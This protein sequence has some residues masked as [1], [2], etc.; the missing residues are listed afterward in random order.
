MHSVPASCPCGQVALE[1]AGAP[2]LSATC[3]CES[4]RK[5][6]RQFEQ[7]PD[8]PTVLNAE[9][10]VD[11][12]LFR[13][14]RVRI[15]RGAEHLREHRLTAASPTRR[16]VTTCCNAPMFLDFTKGHWL[17]L[18]RDRLGAGAP[19]LE[20]GVMAKERPPGVPRPGGLPAY[21]TYP[22]KFMI[23]LLTTWAAMG[24]RRPRI[25]W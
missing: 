20:M 24:F 8:A 7:A 21:P 19:P 25:V 2:I 17:N 18:Y 23:K 12:C 9:G 11:Y 16:V 5:A 10:G 3:Y 4:C 1:A 22:P 13:K 6:A 14:D 15:T